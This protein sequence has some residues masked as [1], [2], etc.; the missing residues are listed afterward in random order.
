MYK[1]I[2]ERLSADPRAT[3]IALR[4]FAGISAAIALLLTFTISDYYIFNRMTEYGIIFCLCQWLKKAGLM[5]VVLAAFFNVKSC[6]DGVKYMLPLPLILSCCLYGGFFEITKIADTPAQEIY[7]T[8]NLFFPAWLNMTLFFLQ[9]VTLGLCC[10]LLFLRDGAGADPRAARA[11]GLSVLAAMPLN[12]FENFFDID[13][14]PQDSFLR[15]K[16]FTIWHLIAI[17]ALAGI[18]IGLY[19]FLRGKSRESQHKYLAA[20]AVSLLIQYHSK[21]SVL[22]GDGYNVYTTVF[23]CIPLFICNIGVYV[24]SLSVMLKKRVLY[25][26]SFFIHAAGALTVFV[27]FGKDE[28][29]N[30]GIFCSYSILF[31]CFTHCFL[32]AL[33][34]LPSALGHY[35]FT[36]RQCVTPLIYYFIVIITA[37]LA[38]ALVTSA[39]ME[40]HTADGI[41]LT[42]DEWLMPNYAFTQINPL[43]FEVP[44][45]LTLKIW[46]YEL[47]VLY[48][49]GLY[50]VYVGLFFAFYGF[51]RAFLKLRPAVL[52]AVARRRAARPEQVI[53]AAADLAAGE[54]AAGELA[55]GEAET[56]EVAA[57]E[58]A[59]EVAAT[60][61]GSGEEPKHPAEGAKSGGKE[62]KSGNRGGRAKD[63]KTAERNLQ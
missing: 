33:C 41:Y 12:I 59:Q 1:T 36:I 51:Y 55:A 61:S 10:A 63:K 29:S 2:S 16:N 43:P 50:A 60:D 18:T 8:V 48:I 7:N 5:M 57:Q 38:S 9:N 53:P 6:A 23:A 47:N 17:L 4:A 56:E 54:L 31:F 22:L 27:Y 11:A 15:F 40:W 19:Y 42:P 32:F 26:I 39:S 62:A 14:I 34:V 35:K 21:D 13:G 44:P 20:I 46:H 45:V 28:M 37:S 52:D 3:G 25:A 49:L 24:A 58:V 30:Y